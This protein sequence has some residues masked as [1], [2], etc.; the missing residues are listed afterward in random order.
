VNST[1]STSALRWRTFADIVGFTLGIN[2]W[3]SIVVL[4]AAFV[5]ALDGWRLAAALLPVVVLG[6]G[7]WRRSEAVLLGMFPASVLVPVA[8]TPA[9][10]SQFVYGP[11]RFTLVAIGTVAYLFGVAFFAT[12]HEPPQP[13]SVRNLSS[14][15]SGTPHRWRRRERVYLTLVALAT[16]IPATLVGWIL[17]DSKIQSYL[18][19]MYPGRVALMTTGMAVGALAF[20]MVL[21]QYVFLGILK[22]HR[23]GDRDLLTRLAMMKQQAT[24]GRPRLGFYLG[25]AVAIA[26]MAALLMRQR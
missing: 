9:I 14:V 25:V 21:Y 6:F 2:V 3:V 4:P 17:F 23:T 18:G 13:R 16:L 19:Q 15:A 26:G 12:F 1:P 11:V 20:W 10:A 5:G 22:P 7:L 24:A 8:A